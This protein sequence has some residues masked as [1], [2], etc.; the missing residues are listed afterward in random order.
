MELFLIEIIHP[1][2]RTESTLPRTAKVRRARYRLRLSYF[3]PG[4]AFEVHFGSMYILLGSVSAYLPL[5][6]AGS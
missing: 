5:F 6:D 3:S 1:Q 2:Q 4:S